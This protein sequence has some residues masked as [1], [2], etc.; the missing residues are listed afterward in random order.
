MQ[1]EIPDSPELTAKAEAAGFENAAQYV[2]S[3]IDAD[4]SQ[5]PVVRHPAHADL[6]PEERNRRFRAFIREHAV[7]GVTSVDDSRESIYEGRGL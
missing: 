4:A 7:R 6:D 1:V 2:R 5:K 3:L